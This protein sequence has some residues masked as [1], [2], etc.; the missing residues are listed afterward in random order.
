M[1]PKVQDEA[2]RFRLQIQKTHCS[3]FRDEDVVMSPH[4][5]DL[6]ANLDL[7]KVAQVECLWLT[8]LKGRAGM[9]FGLGGVQRGRRSRNSPGFDTSHGTLPI[10]HMILRCMSLGAKKGPEHVEGAGAR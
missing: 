5:D 8:P 4:P 1:G 10:V 9:L 2:H 6:K 3:Q 7:H